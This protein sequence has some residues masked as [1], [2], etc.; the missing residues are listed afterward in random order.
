MSWRK[1]RLQYWYLDG[2]NGFT[3]DLTKRG[4]QPIGFDYDGIFTPF[5]C[6]GQRKHTGKTMRKWRNK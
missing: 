2:H 5:K 1:H 4:E 6:Q 3:E